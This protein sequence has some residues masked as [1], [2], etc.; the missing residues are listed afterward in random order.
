MANLASAPESLRTLDTPLNI[1]RLDRFFQ[2][3][4]ALMLLQAAKLPEL[5]SW[6]LKQQLGYHLFE[7]TQHADALRRRRQE[8]PGGRRDFGNIDPDLW[9]ILQ[10]ILH[11]KGD[12]VFC[13]ALYA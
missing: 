8:L 5:V 11:L 6:T 13:T 4:K 12:A 7:D 2:I 3:E 10:A 9:K 1:E